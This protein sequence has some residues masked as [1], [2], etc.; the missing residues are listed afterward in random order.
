VVATTSREAATTGDRGTEPAREAREDEVL[1][2]AG[3]E[4]GCGSSAL[5]PGSIAR[6][7]ERGVHDFALVG[8]H[9]ESLASG[10]GHPD[11]TLTSAN[12]DLARSL[13]RVVDLDMPC[14]AIVH[15]WTLEPSVR[16][17]TRC[18]SPVSPF[19]TASRNG[20]AGEIGYNAP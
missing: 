9:G 7:S 19:G 17:V 6:G 16:L 8:G 10:S 18:S 15:C 14:V 1:D 20:R 11:E 3:S 12:A 5:T 4:S 2:R 13:G